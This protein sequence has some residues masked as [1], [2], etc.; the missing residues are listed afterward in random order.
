MFELSMPLVLSGLVLGSLGLGIFIWGKREQEL[1]A[2]VVGLALG[3]LPMCIHSLGLLWLVS[4][5][6]LGGW[7]LAHRHGI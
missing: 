2:V 5:G 3:I 1:S 7:K 4:G 6:L